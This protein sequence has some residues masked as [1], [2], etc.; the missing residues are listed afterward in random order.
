MTGIIAEADRLRD[1]LLVTSGDIAERIGTRGPTVCN[2]AQRYVD[3]PKPL[4]ERHQWSVYY[5][6][7]VAEWYADFR[8]GAAGIT[9]KM[10][11]RMGAES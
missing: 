3:F 5:W 9:A 8:A 11:R 6:P 1:G 10:A 2:W 4:I 7:E